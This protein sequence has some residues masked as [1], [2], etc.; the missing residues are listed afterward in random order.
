MAGMRGRLIFFYFGIK[1][2]LVSQTIKDV[3]PQVKP[4]IQEILK[5]MKSN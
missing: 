3:I 4:A 1:Y 2:E 5:R